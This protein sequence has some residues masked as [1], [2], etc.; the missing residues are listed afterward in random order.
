[1]QREQVTVDSF[2][3]KFLDSCNFEKEDKRNRKIARRELKLAF[4]EIAAQG[5]DNTPVLEYLAQ[6]HPDIKEEGIYVLMICFQIRTCVQ[7]MIPLLQSYEDHQPYSEDP[8]PPPETI[9]TLEAIGVD[10]FSFKW[11]SSP[12]AEGTKGIIEADAL[13]EPLLA[14]TETRRLLEGTFR[15][16]D[17][18]N[19][20]NNQCNTCL[21]DAK[22][23]TTT[24]SADSIERLFEDER[25]LSI[26]HPASIRIGS[27]GDIINHPDGV[28]IVKTIL[29]KTKQMPRHKI[30]V[31]TNFRPNQ[32][33]ELQE[34][35]AMAENPNFFLT[36]SGPFNRDNSIGEKLLEFCRSRNVDFS[37]G[38]TK[39]T[40][41]IYPNILYFPVHHL[42]RIFRTGRSIKEVDKLRPPERL[43]GQTRELDCFMRGWVKTIL[44]PDALWLQVYATG[45]ESP[46]GRVYTPMDTTNIHLF[47]NLPWN[48]QF[49][50]DPEGTIH[51]PNWEKPD[52]EFFERGPI[53]QAVVRAM[54]LPLKEL[55][56]V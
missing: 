39:L 27:S 37:P 45:H 3:E 13:M 20:C 56:F 40:D 6:M 21:N 34:L 32:M 12:Q 2:T 46:T 9:E 49:P 10:P 36:V 29:E 11:R 15:T 19:G 54:G 16:M 1:M 28:R 38:V 14:D 43:K 48:V 17:I 23:L 52:H 7:Q 47:R 41:P 4:D 22:P 33:D 50:E 18:A 42:R 51:A 25:F 5:K 53:I 44:N 31:V 8:L 55:N 24:F 35:I 26:L 30:K